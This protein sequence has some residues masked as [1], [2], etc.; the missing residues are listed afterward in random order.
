MG[1]RY[2]GGETRKFNLGLWYVAV[3]LCL[4]STF[5]CRFFS[6]QSLHPCVLVLVNA[7]LDRVNTSAAEDHLPAS[8]TFRFHNSSSFFVPPH[9]AEWVQLPVSRPLC[10]N[11]INSQRTP[12]AS[13]YQSACLCILYVCVRAE[14]TLCKCVQISNFL[15]CLHMSLDCVCSCM[16]FVLSCSLCSL[17]AALH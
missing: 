1:E 5:S 9:W 17:V 2:V 12:L 10:L 4:P 11:S 3:S 13:E 8:I 7:S 15:H 6:P 16:S 14:S